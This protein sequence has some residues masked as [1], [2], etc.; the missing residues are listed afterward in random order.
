MDEKPRLLDQMRERIRLKHYSIRTE[1]VYCEWVKRYIRFHQYRH[2]L[3]MGAP[4]IEAFLTEL[5]SGAMCRH[6]RKIRRYRRYCFLIKKCKKGDR[7][8]FS[9]QLMAYCFLCALYQARQSAL[10]HRQS[11]ESRWLTGRIAHSA[12]VR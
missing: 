6:Q 11:D 10:S 12:V 8:I 9:G 2:P 4:E 1:R 3:E 7:F 5:T